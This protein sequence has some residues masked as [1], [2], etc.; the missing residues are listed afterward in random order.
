[1]L[2][3]ARPPE[4]ICH[5]GFQWAQTKANDLINTEK[6]QVTPIQRKNY[7]ITFI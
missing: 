4:D 5:E 7:T 3:L 6:G 1:M 2:F